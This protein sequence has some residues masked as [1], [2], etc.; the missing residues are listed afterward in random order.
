MVNTAGIRIG[1]LAIR[2]KLKQTQLALTLAAA[3][4]A[5]CATGPQASAP[6]SI[7]V[8]QVATATSLASIT[9]TSTPAALL[10]PMPTSLLPTATPTDSDVRTKTPAPG[11][12]GPTP[13]STP[14]PSRTRR[15]GGGPD[16]TATSPASVGQAPDTSAYGVT[17]TFFLESDKS[18]YKPGEHVWFDFTLTNLKALPYTYGAVGVILADGSFHTSLSGSSLDAQERLT[19]RDWVSFSAPGDQRLVLAMCISPKDEC[20]T[21]GTWVNLSA[22]VA[23]KVE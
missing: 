7:V 13:T 15:P 4:L 5:G 23:V 21:G 1:W 20:R 14:S 11:T 2:T 17:A 22:V 18:A 19:W 10:S 9:P 12:A 6:D 3:L 16:A 8:G